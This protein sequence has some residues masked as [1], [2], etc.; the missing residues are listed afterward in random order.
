MRNKGAMEMLIQRRL[1]RHLEL[2]KHLT[3][4]VTLV[5]SEKNRADSLNKVPRKWLE[6]TK[7][8]TESTLQV[9]AAALGD[10]EIMA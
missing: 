3:I 4:D 9:C 1:L 5:K 10:D 6:T 2:I 8:E 7:K